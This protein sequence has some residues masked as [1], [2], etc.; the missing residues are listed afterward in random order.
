VV[1]FVKEKVGSGKGYVKSLLIIFMIHSYWASPKIQLS[2]PFVSF[3]MRKIN[4]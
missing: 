1:V 3:M 4:S 2:V